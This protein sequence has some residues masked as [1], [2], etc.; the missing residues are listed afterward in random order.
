MS[1]ITLRPVEPSDQD[2]LWLALYFASH[3]NDEPETQPDDIR[4]DPDLIRYA[5]GW[6]R[7]GDV[8][9]VAEDGAGPVGAAWARLLPPD[10]ATDPVWVDERTP[11]LAIA[12][13]PGNEGRGI[14][15]VMLEELI[16]MAREMHP[17]IVLSVRLRNPAIRLYQ[18]H[19]FVETA[20][21][22]NRI[23]TESVKMLLTL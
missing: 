8:G 14:G 3:S 12:V 6:G 15:S 21:M 7:P 19:G 11:E 16:G 18:R 4:S 17:A 2:F 9:V 13:L 5:S 10:K 22:V 20:R 23:G 1:P